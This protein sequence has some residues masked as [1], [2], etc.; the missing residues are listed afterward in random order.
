MKPSLTHLDRESADLYALVLLSQG[1][2]VTVERQEDGFNLVVREDLEQ[3]ALD[4]LG[5]FYGE[6]L[7]SAAVPG[8]K[9]VPA[10]PWGPLGVAL[11]LCFV[12]W[13]VAA[14]GMERKWVLEYGSSALY[15]LQGEL[16]RIV[17]A[18]FFHADLE[19]LLGNVA[20]ILIF[21]VPVCTRAG[22][23]FGLLLILLTGGMGNLVTAHLYRTAHLSIG[24]STSVMGA[25]GLL[26]GFQV[27]KR[28]GIKGL[29]PKILLPVGAGA[30][31]VGMLSGGENTDIMAHLFGFV[32]GLML[33]AGFA[34]VQG[35][36]GVSREQERLALALLAVILGGALVKWW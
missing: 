6:N 27:V 9:R 15:I 2:D 28:A 20:G 8:E 16:Y 13:G 32:S 4:M 22:T 24:A 29:G 14:R 33:G 18:L 36:R 34:W 26:T 21:G 7:P 17:T 12:H 19:H 5:R 23:W 11:V 35:D 25:A 30:A 1:L 10:K 3:D 31:L